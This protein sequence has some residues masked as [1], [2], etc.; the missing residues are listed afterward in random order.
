MQLKRLRPFVPVLILFASVSGMAVVFQ[1]FLEK[2]SVS[3]ELL[4]VGNIILFLVTFLSFF[5]YRRAL[6]A[7]STANFL[8]NVYGGLFLKLFVCLIAVFV[9]I[10]TMRTAINKSGL[11]I[12][13]FLYLL[14][15]FLEVSILMKLSKQEKNA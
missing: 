13:M 12:L 4:I 1:R 11:F 8:G 5:L 7:G 9:Y 2:Y 15:T 10:F 3:Q 6:T 14:Y